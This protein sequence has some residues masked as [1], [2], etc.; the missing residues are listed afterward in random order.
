MALAEETS[1]EIICKNINKGNGLKHISLPNV[2]E[3]L[4]YKDN[5]KLLKRN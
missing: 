2:I 4:N 1:L 3:K 5:Y